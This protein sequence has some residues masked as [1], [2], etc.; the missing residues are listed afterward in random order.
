MFLIL[1]TFLLE[2]GSSSF[3]PESDQEEHQQQK[4]HELKFEET[5]KARGQFEAHQINIFYFNLKT[6]FE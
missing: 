5:A 1:D 2:Q 6:A 4:T 3:R